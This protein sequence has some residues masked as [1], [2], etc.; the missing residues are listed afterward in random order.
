MKSINK[1]KSII[2]SIIC[3]SLL[4]G[5]F[6]VFK[7][8]SDNKCSSNPKYECIIQYIE[9]SMVNQ[10]DITDN[11]DEINEY[12]EDKDQD[13]EYYF[14]KGYLDYISENAR[15][16]IDNF[17]I[18]SEKIT[19]ND[20]PFVKIYT[21]TLLNECLESEE[22]IE[23]LAENCKKALEYISKEKEYKN[24]VSLIWRNASTLINSKSNIEEAINMLKDYK[25]NV[26]GLT[27]ETKVRLI[28]N[29]GQ[30]YTL[31]YRYS[32]SI[33]CYLDALHIL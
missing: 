31:I 30:L 8:S 29:I 6:I 14:I 21:Y 9:D 16:A 27:N 3:F 32:D 15:G 17:K 23:S 22:E 7:N 5:V 19:K 26:R 13:S 1:R 25:N 24:N 12:L 28:P 10:I 33:Y 11:I 2:I 4:I 18:C 20:T